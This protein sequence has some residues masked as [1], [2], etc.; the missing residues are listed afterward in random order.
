MAFNINEFIG[1]GLTEGGA[2]PSL[3]QVTLNFPPGFTLIPGTEEKFSFTCRATTIPASTIGQVDVP[4]F[5]R[6]IKLAGDRTFADWNVTVMND[7]DYLV[8]DAFEAWHNSINSI[9][10]NNKALPGNVYKSLSATV[11]HFSKNGQRD[12]KAYTFVNIFPVNI[13]EM[14]LDWEATNQIQTFG[15]T[16]AYD[17]WLP[18]QGSTGS[19]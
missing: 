1:R 12:I 9:T 15:V 16:F 11:V 18:F 2:R 8:R 6:T 14:S 13:A 7:E 17:Y 19:E 3:F 10:G 5:G 4:Y